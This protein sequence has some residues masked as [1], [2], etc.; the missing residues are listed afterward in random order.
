MVRQ[1]KEDH[2]CLHLLAYH[3]QMRMYFLKI[4]MYWSLNSKAL[5]S[6]TSRSQCIAHCSMVL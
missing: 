2:D 5:Q 1:G 6:S 3:V 4:L